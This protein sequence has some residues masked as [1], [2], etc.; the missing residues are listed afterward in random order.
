MHLKFKEKITNPLA[1]IN[2]TDD[3]FGIILELFLL[4]A[5][6]KG[7]FA[8]FWNLFLFQKKLKKKLKTCF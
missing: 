5:T 3:D 8:V 2:V 4:L 6:L 1:Q 7:K